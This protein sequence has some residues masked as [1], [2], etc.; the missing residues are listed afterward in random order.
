MQ[1]TVK[2]KLEPTREQLCFLESTM[3]EYIRLINEIVADFVEADAC[4]GYTSKTVVADLPSALR[5]QAIQDAKSVFRKYK[6][7][8]RASAGL[9]PEEQEAV[10]API[11][12][13]PVAIWNNQDYSLVGDILSL[14]VPV[15]GKSRRIGIRAILTDY[16]RERPEGELRTLRITRKSGKYIAQIA[17]ELPEEEPTG[18]RG[19]GCRSGAQDSGCSRCRRRE[20]QILG[21]RQGKRVRQG[22]ASFGQAG[23]SASSRRQKPSE[24][25]TAKNSA[26]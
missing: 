9:E 10:K 8:V 5:N 19:H 15:Q 17:V 26:G 25:A 20:N 18:D 6:K 21:L 14:S 12:K 3:K 1:I 22:K 4:L 11:L 16:Q 24:S 7:R 23:S 2:I 13:T